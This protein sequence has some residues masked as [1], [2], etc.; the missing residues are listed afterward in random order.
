MIFG[1][2]FLGARKEQGEILATQ[3]QHGLA[4]ES[5]WNDTSTG[6]VHRLFCLGISILFYL[7]A[8]SGWRKITIIIY[9]CIKPALWE[10]KSLPFFFF[11]SLP[12]TA[13]LMTDAHPPQRFSWVMVVLL[14][15]NPG[16]SLEHHAMLFHESECADAGG[17]LSV[18]SL[19]VAMVFKV[20]LSPHWMF[21]SVWFWLVRPLEWLFQ[22][23]MV[24]LRGQ[25]LL[26]YWSA[27]SKSFLWLVE[28]WWEWFC[29]DESTQSESL[30]MW[31][32]CC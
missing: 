6:Y 11:P 1:V 24:L 13:Q 30:N 27:K 20:L 32:P 12:D 10:F 22:R 9:S 4:G 21:T 25:P 15:G 5:W 28:R 23:L 3:P 14:L 19:R 2:N 16:S 17:D 7:I 18:T 29:S 26:K 31:Q 8:L